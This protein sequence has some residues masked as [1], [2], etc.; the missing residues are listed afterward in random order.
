MAIYKIFP[1]KDTT[2][3]TTTQ[4]MNTGLDEIIEASTYI[5]KTQPQVSRYLMKFSQIEIN[6][7]T[8]AYISGS[9]VSVLAS[10]PD[11][12]D[13]LFDQTMIASST[14]PTQSDG[15]GFITPSWDLIPSSSTGNGRG[16][17]FNVQTHGAYFI[18]NRDIVDTLVITPTFTA[19]DGTYG[20]FIVSNIDA[21]AT[22][23]TSSLSA[24]INLVV[25]D[26]KVI[27]APIINNGSASYINQDYFSYFNSP[28]T[29]VYLT[30]AA[31]DST[32]GAGVFTFPAA[33]PNDT[34]YFKIGADDLVT[35]ISVLEGIKP[36]GIGYKPGDKLIFK[37]ESFAGYPMSD[38]VTITLSPPATSASNW[39]DREFGVDL[40]NSAAVVNG[41]GMDQL[42]KIYPIS[43]SWNMGTGKY[44]NIP[45]STDGASWIFTNYSGSNLLPND[46][47]NRWQ[48]SGSL[49]LN[50]TYD[51]TQFNTVTTVSAGT[52]TG[53]AAVGD[54]SG[55]AA[56]IS[57][58]STLVGAINIINAVQV[59]SV[60]SGYT[61]GETITITIATITATALGI[62]SSNLI[63]SLNPSD[64]DLG[65]YASTSYSGSNP[66]GGNWYTGSN[67]GLPI[68]QSQS[69]S[70][71]IGVDLS[72]DVT[73]TIKTWTTHSLVSSSKGFPNDGFIIKQSSSKEFVN[74]QATTATF[75]Y[76]SIDTNTIY[77]PLLDLKWNDYYYE[78]GSST[79]TTLTTP[80]AFISIYN[81]AGTYYSQSIER[82][83]IAAIPKYPD[84]VFQTASLYTT[85]FYLPKDSSSYAIKDTDTNEFVIPFNNTYTQ[86]SSDVTS[87][88]FDVYMNGLEPER[89]YS[90]LFK[91]TID[92][93][94]K[95]FDEDI[96]FKVING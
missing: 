4:S 76:F 95:V 49:K 48:A 36:Y 52:V 78:T 96:M 82:F 14:Y 93:T 83:R 20:P 21:A 33:Y 3:Y 34:F 75:R 80:E 1:T 43:G 62:P 32:V 26:N 10:F 28:G 41:L 53:I 66:G 69:F 30:P 79:N 16:Q 44:N 50:Q 72:V 81:N 73:N 56:V 29:D 2:L 55:V 35:T 7:W 57:I 68:V 22:V 89:H 46:G 65:N 67:I 90:I 27:S 39:T 63:I 42:L 11:A 88:Y 45:M 64:L 74:L 85:N 19:N 94:T 40:R 51:I 6:N 58:T 18:P 92:G 87:S 37:S 13:F 38:D 24:S 31:I 5:E 54:S 23:A 12:G 9:G 77:P 15:V 86:I 91:T 25:K 61:P 59:T 60:G 84:V 70:Y 71:G 17:H 8:Q 47:S